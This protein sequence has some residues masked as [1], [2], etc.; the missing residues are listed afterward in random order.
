[1]LTIGILVYIIGLSIGGLGC[2]DLYIKLSVILLILGVILNMSMNM[3]ME[4][5]LL[6]GLL[7]IS[8]DSK[9]LENLVYILGIMIYIIS[10]GEDK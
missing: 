10:I 7:K 2:R 6:G 4:V 9:N 5:S 8:K 3:D 1:M